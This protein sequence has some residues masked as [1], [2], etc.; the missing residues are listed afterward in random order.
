[1]FVL[2]SGADNIKQHSDTVSCMLCA[3]CMLSGCLCGMERGV[4]LLC[5]GHFL[6]VIMSSGS[7]AKQ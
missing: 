7:S 1:V 5:G 4:S 2:A 6:K 3:K